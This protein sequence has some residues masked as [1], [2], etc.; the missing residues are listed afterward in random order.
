MLISNRWQSRIALL[1]ALGM[2]STAALPILVSTPAMAGKEP[3]VIGQL[4]SQ[5]SRVTVPAG[6]TIPVRYD[7]AEKLIIHPKETAPVTLIVAKNIRSNSGRIMIP[8]GSQIKGELKPA[9]GGTQFFAQELIF[10]NSGERLPINAISEI[11]TA[12]QTINERT[13]PNILTDAAIGAGAG[14]LLGGIFGSIRPGQVLAGAGIGGGIAALERGR[15]ETKL[16]VIDPDT[17]L[18]LFLRAD[19]VSSRQQNADFTPLSQT[20]CKGLQEAVAQKLGVEVNLT[21]SPFQD[22][23]NEQRRYNITLTLAQMEPD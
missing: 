10:S 17:D 22:Y 14:A 13:K 15:K 5:S 6:T 21:T 4:F 23:V 12:T 2:T 19:L 20:Q 7:N 11:I 8:A 16:V 1:V 3:Y 18:H 9:A